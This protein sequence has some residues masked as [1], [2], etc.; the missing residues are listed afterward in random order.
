MWDVRNLTTCVQEKIVNFLYF[1]YCLFIFLKG[2][3]KKWDEAIMDSVL[4]PNDLT[5]VTGKN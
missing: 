3:Q 1:F 5:L 2:S 4:I